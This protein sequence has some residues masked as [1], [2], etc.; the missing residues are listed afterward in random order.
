MRSSLPHDFHKEARPSLLSSGAAHTNYRGFFN[1]SLI[2]L[3]A[4]N[5]RLIIENILKY[6]LIAFDGN[7]ARQSLEV[8][9]LR[10]KHP[11]LIETAVCALLLNVPAVLC[12]GIERWAASAGAAAPERLIF[13]LHAVLTTAVL[14]APCAVVTYYET[15]FGPGSVLVFLAT[16]LWLK[17]VSFAHTNGAL[18]QET[19]K[20]KKNKERGKGKAAAAAAAAAATTTTTARSAA[21][22]ATPV[23]AATADPNGIYPHNLTVGDLYFFF[24]LPT[25]CYQTKY[26]RTERIRK[27]WLARRVGEL[28]LCLLAMAL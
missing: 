5:L 15:A 4:M 6:G 28:V 23:S 2:V 13:A 18:R 17:L 25:L 24:A 14:A 3:F 12:L 19:A 16:V 21:S 9:H 7:V 26:P 20:N 27:R 10:D 8:S 22:A 1:L 11:G